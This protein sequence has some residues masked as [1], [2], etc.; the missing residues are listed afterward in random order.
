M[1]TTTK[2]RDTVPKKTPATSHY[3]TPYGDDAADSRPYRLFSSGRTSFVKS[4]GDLA[5][6]KYA[7]DTNLSALLRS[8]DVRRTRR[9]P[10]N[11]M[12][13]TPTR[14]RKAGF[15]KDI[16]TYI[17]PDFDAPLDDFADYQ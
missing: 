15:A 10:E 5:I 1:Q 14:P 6:S 2:A 17:A 3:L 8:K 11:T 7:V 16:I 12:S 4:C 13:V 9:Q